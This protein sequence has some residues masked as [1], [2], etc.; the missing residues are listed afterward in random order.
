MNY[1]PELFAEA[2]VPYELFAEAIVP[3]YCAV[4]NLVAYPGG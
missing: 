4:V 2:I 1:L 3:G